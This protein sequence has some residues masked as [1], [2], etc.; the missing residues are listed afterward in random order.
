MIP[1]NSSIKIEIWD[2]LCCCVAVERL[3]VKADA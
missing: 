3:I 2:R 1:R